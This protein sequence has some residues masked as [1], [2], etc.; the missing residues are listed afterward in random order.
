MAKKV[1]KEQ[2]WDDGE[3]KAAGKTN[4]GMRVGKATADSVDSAGVR[5]QDIHPTISQLALKIKLTK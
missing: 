5:W 1:P 2:G 4:E 3:R